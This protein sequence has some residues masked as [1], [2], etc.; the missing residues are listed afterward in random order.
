[1]EKISTKKG[2][3]Y[4]FRLPAGKYSVYGSLPWKWSVD[5]TRLDL[6]GKMQQVYSTW[7]SPSVFYVPTAGKGNGYVELQT[8][9]P[10]AFN[11]PQLYLLDLDQLAQATNKLKKQSIGVEL[12]VENGKAHFIVDNKQGKRY[13]QTTIPYESGWIVKLNGKEIMPELLD[14]TLMAIPLVLFFFRCMSIR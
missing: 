2:I 1:M 7:L 3:R 14:N 10:N 9:D 6:N 11:E 13:L 4:E 8:D 5:G 12:N